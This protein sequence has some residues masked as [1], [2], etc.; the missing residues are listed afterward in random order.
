MFG[1]VLFVSDFGEF[2]VGFLGGMV[3]VLVWLAGW[4]GV[5]FFLHLLVYVFY[6]L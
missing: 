6:R 3:L 2:F 5:I 4:V 1:G